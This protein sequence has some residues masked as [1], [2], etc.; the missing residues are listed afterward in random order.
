M[1]SKLS[2]VEL[3][4]S[5]SRFLKPGE[6]AIPNVNCCFSCEDRRGHASSLFVFESV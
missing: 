6:S 4:K 1:S 2:Q 3:Q 5:A